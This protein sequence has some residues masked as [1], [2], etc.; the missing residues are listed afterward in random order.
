MLARMMLHNPAFPN[1]PRPQPS[2]CPPEVLSEAPHLLPPP[3]FADS[4]FL[5]LKPR[6]GLPECPIQNSTP[7]PGLSAITELLYGTS[8]IA[9]ITPGNFLLD[10]FT[11]C[12]SVPLA[13][14][15]HALPYRPHLQQ[16][17]CKCSVDTCK[18]STE[19]LHAS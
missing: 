18:I 11:A 8:F 1:L 7:S 16:V 6:P 17:P 13:N 10:L 9:L 15:T 2:A 12:K 4:S 19:H 14:V 3:I 5:S